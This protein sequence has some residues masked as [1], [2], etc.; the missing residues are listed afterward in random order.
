MGLSCRSVAK[1]STLFLEPVS[2]SVVWYWAD[3]LRRRIR[4]EVKKRRRNFIAMDGTVL[5]AQGQKLWLWSSMD[6]ERK[7]ILVLH[8]SWHRNGL[9]AFRVARR[10]LELCRGRALFLTD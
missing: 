2:K 9:E 6:P 8:V 7:E 1:L 3:K 10:T 5:K 4:L